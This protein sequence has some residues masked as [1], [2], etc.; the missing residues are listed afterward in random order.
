MGDY[1]A[2]RYFRA[3]SVEVYEAVRANL[4]AA[5]GYPNDDTKTLTAICPALDAQTDASGRVYMVASQAECD[6]PV[7]AAL[8]P[9]LLSSGLVEEIDAARY[10]QELPSPALP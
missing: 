8:L 9:Q 2:M 4:D 3:G 5:Y 6:F 10:L 1:A 7:V